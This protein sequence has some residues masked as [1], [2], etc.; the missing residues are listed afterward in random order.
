MKGHAE[1]HVVINRS[2]K[3]TETNSSR[4]KVLTTEHGGILIPLCSQPVLLLLLH[5][6]DFV[7]IIS[8]DF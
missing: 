3:R 6:S 1:H 5:Y 2:M 4:I 7:F 8:P